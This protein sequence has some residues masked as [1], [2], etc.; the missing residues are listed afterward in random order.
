MILFV[1]RK[2]VKI[3][4]YFYRLLLRFVDIFIDGWSVVLCRADRQ[5]VG[6]SINNK[7]SDLWYRF[8]CL[9]VGIG[10][11]GMIICRR[12]KMFVQIKCQVQIRENFFFLY[13]QGTSINKQVDPPVFSTT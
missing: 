10:W 12:E 7:E 8:V 6:T 11:T 2:N 4:I 3:Q 1:G 5:M 13:T 9:F